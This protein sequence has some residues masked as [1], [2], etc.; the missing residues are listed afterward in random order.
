MSDWTRFQAPRIAGIA[1]HSSLLLAILVAV[2]AMVTIASENLAGLQSVLLLVASVLLALIFP[3]LAYRFYALLQSEYSI[4]REGLVLRW[5]LRQVRMPHEMILDNALGEELLELPQLPRWRWPGSVLGKVGD[6]ELGIVEFMAADSSKLVFIGTHERVY[7]ISPEEPQ[8]FLSALRNASERGSLEKGRV[9]SIEPSFVLSQAWAE[10]IVR[11]LL[12]SGA[13]L[14]LLTLIMTG[15]VVQG[16]E[17]ISLGFSAL[18]LPDEPV[19]AAQL[20]LL[21]ALNLVIYMGNLLLGLVLYREE[22]NGTLAKLLWGSS[23]L[24]SALFVAAIIFIA[25]TP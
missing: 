7:A 5:G 13:A 12:L 8:A 1:F 2:G 6:E 16:R 23:L 9:I 4:G 19:A 17:T 3:I 10:K 22:S 14:A 15:V 25:R 21:P 11:T 24:T 20:Y 18:A